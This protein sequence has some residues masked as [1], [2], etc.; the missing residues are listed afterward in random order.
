MVA[1][2]C[3]GEAGLGGA[4][5]FFWSGAADA[6]MSFLG[7]VSGAWFDLQLPFCDIGSMDLLALDLCRTI[8]SPRHFFQR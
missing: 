2:V 5:V 4:H 3:H 1:K 6:L 7:R 8:P